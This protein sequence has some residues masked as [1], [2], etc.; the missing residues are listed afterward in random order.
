MWA[1]NPIN[2]QAL[3]QRASSPKT[4]RLCRTEILVARHFSLEFLLDALFVHRGVYTWASSSSTSSNPGRIK[5]E[6][7]GSRNPRGPKGERGKEG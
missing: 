5:Y 3:S 7:K 6:K 1:N 4:T 2:T